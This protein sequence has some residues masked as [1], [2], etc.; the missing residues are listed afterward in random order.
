[1]FFKRLGQIP[2][3]QILLCGLLIVALALPNGIPFAYAACTTSGVS[4]YANSVANPTVDL[5]GTCQIGCPSCSAVADADDC[6]VN[7]EIYQCAFHMTIDLEIFT[8]GCEVWWTT[9]CTQQCANAKHATG[10]F[11]GTGIT[12][13]VYCTQAGEPM[14]IEFRAT[15]GCNDCDPQLFALG[16]GT[17][18]L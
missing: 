3:Y 15:A 17:C 2:N 10:V 4:V 6:T 7:G 11:S 18:S 12:K 8:S 5:C 13:S 9:F 1:M 14:R 16:T